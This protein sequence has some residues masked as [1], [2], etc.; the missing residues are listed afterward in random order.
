MLRNDSFLEKCSSK[1]SSYEE[2]QACLPAVEDWVSVHTHLDLN[3]L[4]SRSVC[5]V[6]RA[7]TDAV[8]LQEL[9]RRGALAQGCTS[10]EHLLS[11]IQ[12]ALK[13]APHNLKIALCSQKQGK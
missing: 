1:F 8:L 10:W 13:I 6:A 11:T 12:E 9:E 4:G 3:D 2:F 7:T 5:T